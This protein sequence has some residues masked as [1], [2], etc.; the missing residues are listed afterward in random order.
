MFGASSRGVGESVFWPEY[1]CVL[2]I[3]SYLSVGMFLGGCQILQAETTILF[4]R[5]A[6][7]YYT[8]V[9]M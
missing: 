9:C 2:R 3:P 8:A 4:A 7:W 5:I 1:C 6:Y